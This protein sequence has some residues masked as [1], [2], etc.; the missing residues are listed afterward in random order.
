[1]SDAELVPTA[2]VSALLAK[3]KVTVSEVLRVAKGDAK[4]IALAQTPLPKNPGLDE[5][6]WEAVVV[7]RDLLDHQ[8]V[9]DRR[10]M[11][12]EVE[13][14][15]LTRTYDAVQKALAGLNRSRDQIKTTAF[16]HFDA[17]ALDDGK[18]T[19]DTAFTKEGW[20]IIADKESAIVEGLPVKLTREVTGGKV[21]LT[22][23]G[24]H[25]LVEDGVIEQADLLKM[26]RQKR[27]IDEARALEWIRQNPERAAALVEATETGSPTA[28][29]WLRKND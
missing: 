14:E 1:M 21:A 24:L 20:A 27:V 13:L 5:E 10:R 18:V 15:R 22:V 28:Q 25:A 26:T 17:V 12:S 16:N 29:F 7:A 6:A 19:T 2:Q 4:Q 9:P 8:P 23:E 11:L 3:P